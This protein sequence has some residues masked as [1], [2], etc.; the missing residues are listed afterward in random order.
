MKREEIIKLY[1]DKLSHYQIIVKSLDDQIFQNSVIRTAIFMAGAACLYF[2]WGEGLVL[3]MS[4]IFSIALFLF[5]VKRQLKLTYERN[6]NNELL[7]INEKELKC[8]NKDFKKYENG[9]E[10]KDDMHEY[11]ND[12][13]L[14]G[15][16]SFYQYINRTKLAQSR[17]DLANLLKANDIN[18]IGVKQK[19]IQ[20]LQQKIEWRQNFSAE[21][22]LVEIETKPQEIISW[23]NNYKAFVPDFMRIAAYIFSTIS[24]VILG[25]FIA[26]V[27]PEGIFILWF[28]LGLFISGFFVKKI[29]NLQ[30]TATKSSSTFN[31]YHLLLARIETEKWNSAE[32]KE[33]VK[34]S[35]FDN[36][37][38]SHYIKQFSKL[39]NS[40]DQRTNLVVGIVA[41][42]LFLRDLLIVGKIEKWLLSHPEKVQEWFDIITFFDLQNSLGN[43]AF[44]HSDYKFPSINLVQKEVI[45]AALLG[46]PL[47][48]E[49]K[50]VDNDFDIKT[51]DFYII[52]GAN[53]A[54]KSTF[55]RTVSL[56][57]VM[58]NI[59]LP[60]CAK[61]FI[62]KPIRLISSMRT[63]D[64]LS[65]EE[66]YFFSE[67][68]RLR[69]IIDRVEKDVYFIILD[70]I[71]K[72]TNSVDKA[73]G[74]KKFL[75]RLLR[76]ASTGIIATHDLSLCET[77]TA[78]TEVRNYYFD[79]EIIED[80]LSFDYTLKKGICQNMNASFL[81]RKM[82]LI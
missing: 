51:D 10:Y 70:E 38:G 45:Q 28:F 1:S 53:M 76:S 41:N 61:S 16:G 25:L 44:N 14:F 73:E 69:Y 56:S 20:E 66:S 43:F 63:S 26:E 29:N 7:N 59:G 23:I 75:E 39:L 78:Y 35:Y 82:D 74:S 48:K 40:L 18:E 19:I 22:A 46:H 3:A 2:L 5:F 15:T 37:S 60:V 21:A 34:K 54:G 42:G 65:D 8:I 50:R 32:I 30:A 49:E 11:C 33:V 79:A 47:L 68:K 6:F 77:S 62:Y 81:L 4:L 67:L 52:T 80:E 71:L 13:D 9:V 31:Q 27:I 55:L 24:I 57:I 17:I 58:A 36:H 72:G 12:I 64:S